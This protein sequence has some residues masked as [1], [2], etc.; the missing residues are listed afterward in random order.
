MAAIEVRAGIAGAFSDVILVIDNYDSFTFNL[1]QGLGALDGGA[2]IR[3]A[4]NDAISVREIAD[5]RPAHIVISPGPCTPAEAGVSV[6]VIREFAARIPIL[7]VCLG[8]QCIGAALGMSVVPAK[9]LM[10]GKTS[11]VHHDG[12]GLFDGMPSPF[13]AARYHSLILRR[14]ELPNDLIATAWTS[15]GEL[16]GLRHREWPLEGVQFHPESFMTENGGRLLGKFVRMGSG[17]FV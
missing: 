2:E 13:R 12:A 6:A 1:V 16:M 11:E 3:V 9:R 14:E 8:Q 7:G 4:R 10:H 5:L 17:I 15:D